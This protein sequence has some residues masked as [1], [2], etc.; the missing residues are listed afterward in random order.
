MKSNSRIP[1]ILIFFRKHYLNFIHWTSPNSKPIEISN[2]TVHGRD[3]KV[4]FSNRGKIDHFVDFS[5]F[6][7]RGFHN[8]SDITNHGP[9]WLI[10]LSTIEKRFFFT[11]SIVTPIWSIEKLKKASEDTINILKKISNE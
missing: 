7:T 11:F 1:D 5:G 9:Q 3:L 10:H 4:L 8:S 2:E 6:K